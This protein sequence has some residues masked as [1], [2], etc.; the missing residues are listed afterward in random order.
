M[1]GGTKTGARKTDEGMGTH[2]DLPIPVNP[3]SRLITE[4]PAPVPPLRPQRGLALFLL[5]SWSSFYNP[6]LIPLL[7][8]VLVRATGGN[9]CK[10]QD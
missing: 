8:V 7:S 9:S 5:C 6:N 1:E 3:S 2:S 4:P 10:G